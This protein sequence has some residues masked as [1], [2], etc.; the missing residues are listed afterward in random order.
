MCLC[1]AVTDHEINDLVAQGV[2][3]LEGISAA[4]DAGTVCGGCL[5]RVEEVLEEANARRGGHVA[6]SRRPR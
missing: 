5:P 1:R 6:G 4:C 2:R 3:T